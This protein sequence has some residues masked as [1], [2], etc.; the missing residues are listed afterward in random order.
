M[1]LID[2]LVWFGNQRRGCFLFYFFCKYRIF[3]EKNKE[4]KKKNWIIREIV[5]L[6]LEEFGKI[7]CLS[8]CGL[9]F[10]FVIKVF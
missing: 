4:N 1:F 7:L 5:Y 8:L 6:K 3:L 9:E 2:C 10:I